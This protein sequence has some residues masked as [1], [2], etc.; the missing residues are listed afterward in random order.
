LVGDAGK[1]GAS[2]RTP[3]RA[4]FK[5]LEFGGFGEV[6]VVDFHGGDDHCEGFFGGGAG[7]GGHGFDVLQKFDEGLVEAEIFTELVTLPFST[8]YRPS[9]VMPVMIFS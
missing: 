3:K 2:S 9:R 5:C 1:A 8:R 4:Y 6:E 7:R